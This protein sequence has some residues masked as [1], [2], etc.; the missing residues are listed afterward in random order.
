MDYSR[1]RITRDM[2]VSFVY[3]EMFIGFVLFRAVGLCVPLSLS[4]KRETTSQ[5]LACLLFPF[6]W[7]LTRFLDLLRTVVYKNSFSCLAV[8]C[9]AGGKGAA[10]PPPK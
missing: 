3:G 2:L 7:L 9:R 1:G 6:P 4:K 10:E 5:H 8:L